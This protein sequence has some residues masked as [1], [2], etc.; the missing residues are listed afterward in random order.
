MGDL[1][2]EILANVELVKEKK[3]INSGDT[4]QFIKVLGDDVK[5][6]ISCMRDELDSVVGAIGERDDKCKLDMERIEQK[7]G[8]TTQMKN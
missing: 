5:Q 2:S 6:F 1:Q 4:I 3:K 8:V 7:I